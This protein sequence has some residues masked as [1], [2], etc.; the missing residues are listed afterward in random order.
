MRFHCWRCRSMASWSRT[1]TTAPKISRRPSLEFS[2]LR[3][4]PSKR[5]EIPA[6]ELSRVD[7]KKRAVLSAKRELLHITRQRYF[8][9]CCAVTIR[10]PDTT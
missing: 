2:A 9:D 4:K 5:R 10:S 3:R 1:G 7:W 6:I 8:C